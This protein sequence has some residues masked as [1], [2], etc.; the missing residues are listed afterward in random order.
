MHAIEPQKLVCRFG[1]FVVVD[2]VEFQVQGGEV[3]GFLG[4]KTH[5]APLAPV[6]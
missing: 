4:P 6:W 5:S 2:N 3:F 1:D